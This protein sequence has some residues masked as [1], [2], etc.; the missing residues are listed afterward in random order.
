M[1]L[2]RCLGITLSRTAIS[3]FYEASVA[4]FGRQAEGL[5][6]V[7]SLQHYI[8]QYMY[9]EVAIVYATLR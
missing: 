8:H 9:F 5:T 7:A 6:R 3:Q 2:C 1:R 4:L